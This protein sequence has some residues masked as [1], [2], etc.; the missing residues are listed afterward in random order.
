MDYEKLGMQVALE[1]K[2]RDLKNE[3]LRIKFASSYPKES[4]I[5]Q[6]HDLS[7]ECLELMNS[8]AKKEK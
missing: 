7:K 2:T 6:I 1:Q 8:I 5:Q 3:A 4:V